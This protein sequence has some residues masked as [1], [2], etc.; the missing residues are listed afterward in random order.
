MTT[1]DGKALLWDIVENS[2]YIFYRGAITAAASAKFSHDGKLIVTSSETEGS[3]VWDAATVIL[4]SAEHNKQSLIASF[5]D[6]GGKLIKGTRSAEFS[7]DGKHVLVGSSDGT[8]RLWDVASGTEVVSFKGHTG[9]VLS[10]HFS[11]DGKRIV[12]ASSD[13]TA[14]VWDA[15]RGKEIMQLLGSGGDVYGARFSG[16]GTRIVTAS[17]DHKVRVWDSQTGAQMLRF[18][19]GG[20]PYDAAFT[21]NGSR[22]IVAMYDGNLELFDVPWTTQRREE[23]FSRACK[24]KLTDA[25]SFTSDDAQDPLLARFTLGNP[26]ERAGPLISFSSVFRRAISQIFN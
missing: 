20:D 5:K 22:V 23:L 7:L 11:G 4:G 12:N 16:D 3:Q 8:T 6:V 18:D 13:R 17:G 2:Q 26:C 25:Q 19:V 9:V 1:T 21:G 15:G 14:R 10:A 24:E